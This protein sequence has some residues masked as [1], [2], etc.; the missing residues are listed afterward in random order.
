MPYLAAISM[1]FPRYIPLG[2]DSAGYGKGTTEL[3]VGHGHHIWTT[4]SNPWIAFGVKLSNKKLL[5]EKMAD[6]LDY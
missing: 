3:A 6:I 2:F 5:G 4:G 1:R